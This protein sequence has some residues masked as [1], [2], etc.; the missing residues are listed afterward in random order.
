MKCKL[1]ALMLAVAL[2]SFAQTGPT[3]PP[4]N[5]QDSPACACCNH[6]KGGCADC[7]KDG[8][9]PMMSGSHAG[10]KC[11]MMAKNGKT[12]DGK[13]CCSSNQCSMHA[14]GGKGCCCGNMEDKPSGM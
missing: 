1:L 5:K 10:M 8:K 7:C 2:T 12:A 6:D 13:V 11:P 4:T 3:T 9:C 14:K